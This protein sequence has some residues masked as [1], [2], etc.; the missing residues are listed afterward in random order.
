MLLIS[1]LGITH[2]STALVTSTVPTL[3]SLPS[4]RVLSSQACLLPLPR[5][6]FFPRPCLPCPPASR[7]PTRQTEEK[8]EA[9]RAPLLELTPVPT[10]MGLQT[11]T[12]RC[13]LAKP[14]SRT[15]LTHTHGWSARRN[16]S[17]LVCFVAAFERGRFQVAEQD[18]P[19]SRRLR[20][21]QAGRQRY[22]SKLKQR[23]GHSPAS[24]GLRD[25]TLVPGSSRG[26]IVTRPAC[27]ASEKMRQAANRRRE[28]K[29]AGDPVFRALDLNES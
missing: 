5:G 15:R 25:R 3:P 28:R 18:H 21:R 29:L 20:D 23:E 17:P 24:L 4:R 14:A 6:S 7:T 19:R 2:Q 26:M 11:P 10:Q 13:R 8:G 16:F 1:G 12:G 27:K 22:T 9:Q